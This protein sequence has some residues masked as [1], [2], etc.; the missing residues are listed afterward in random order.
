L[1]PFKVLNALK[2][3]QL[4]NKTIIKRLAMHLHTRSY[5]IGVASGKKINTCLPTVNKKS[6]ISVRNV[7]II[8]IYFYKT[9]ER[10]IAH[11]PVFISLQSVEY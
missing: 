6:I 10:N 5:D 1:Y 11:I 4:F 7:I 3:T 9:L 2:L 8:N